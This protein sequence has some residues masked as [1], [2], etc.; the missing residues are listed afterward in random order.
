M[1]RF[2]SVSSDAVSLEEAFGSFEGKL[3]TRAPSI[4]GSPGAFLLAS[5]FLSF[6]VTSAAAAA[7]GVKPQVVTTAGKSTPFGPYRLAI[8][9]DDNLHRER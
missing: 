3:I 8:Q 9:V 2:S 5:A 1:S 6:L 4:F 7:S